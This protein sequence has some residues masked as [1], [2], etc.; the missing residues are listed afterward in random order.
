MNLLAWWADAAYKRRVD[1]FWSKR[2]TESTTLIVTST[3]RFREDTLDTA[4]DELRRL[5]DNQ[6]VRVENIQNRAGVLTGASAV[7]AGL[8]GVGA[9]SSGWWFIPIAFV[10]VS[11]IIGMGVFYPSTGN[12]I[13]PDSVVSLANGTKPAQLKHAIA[14]GLVEEYAAQEKA[15]RKHAG[16]LKGGFIVLIIAVASVSITASLAST[17]NV[18]GKPEPTSTSTMQSQ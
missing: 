10:A 9:A 13:Q 2:P 16:W 18:D 11:A 4:V 3:G 15:N 12:A 8:V 1:H 14:T 6:T 7:A 5:R 17:P